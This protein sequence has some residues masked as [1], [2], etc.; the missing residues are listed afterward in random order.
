MLL[1]E[2][3]LL[4]K[5]LAKEDGPLAPD[6]TYLQDWMK[7]PNMGCVYLIGAD[8]D[9]YEKPILGDL[10]S[11]KRYRGH[12]LATRAVADFWIRVW[13]NIIFW[14]PKV[15]YSQTMV[16]SITEMANIEQD[17]KLRHVRKHNSLCRLNPHTDGRGHWNNVC[18]N[19]TDPRY[20]HFVLRAE[21]GST[22]SSNCSL[23][24]DL[25]CGLGYLF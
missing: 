16:N 10:I 3:L 17:T 1:D 12:N 14:T 13:H 15:R 24:V 20:S 22:S 11:V 7:R 25:F 6:M 21:Y 9:V 23:H 4:Q 2:S 19:T 5:M 18:I 8:S